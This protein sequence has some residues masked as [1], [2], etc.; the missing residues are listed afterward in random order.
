MIAK[1]VKYFPASR[2]R[3][4]IP[5]DILKE[6]EEDNEYNVEDRKQIPSIKISSSHHT[7]QMQPDSIT[8]GSDDD[9]D[10]NDFAAILKANIG[11]TYNLMQDTTENE[12]QDVCTPL[13]ESDGSKEPLGKGGEQ[14]LYTAYG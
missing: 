11:E 7:Q 3:D 14:S 9:D 10:Y 5:E 13:A 8:Q 12:V 6:I 2:Y 4:V 1:V